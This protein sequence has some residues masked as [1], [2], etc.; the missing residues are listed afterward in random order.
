MKKMRVGKRGAYYTQAGAS[1]SAE[2]GRGAVRRKGLEKQGAFLF[3]HQQAADRHLKVESHAVV[4]AGDLLPLSLLLLLSLE[5]GVPLVPLAR[6]RVPVSGA[7]VG[8]DRVRRLLA[9]RRDRQRSS[10]RRRR[11]MPRNGD[12]D[13]AAA[14]GQ[15]LD[16]VV[17]QADENLPQ[18]HVV[19]H[20][21]P[22][23][24]AVDLVRQTYTCNNVGAQPLDGHD[25]QARA[26]V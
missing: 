5:G 26:S 1:H 21:E 22:G 7:L 3:A 10:R 14:R 13:L 12:H 18:P 8:R 24:V 17:E 4:S 23:H 19:C 2:V 25:A 20:K 11:C 9:P 15:Q 16:R 6:G